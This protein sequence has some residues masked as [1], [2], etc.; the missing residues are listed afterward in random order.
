M[1]PKCCPA[2]AAKGFQPVI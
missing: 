2:A 1:G